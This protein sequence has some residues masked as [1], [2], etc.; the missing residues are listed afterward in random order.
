METLVI[1]SAILQNPP[2]SQESRERRVPH[3]LEDLFREHNKLTTTF[4]ALAR[5]DKPLLVLAMIINLFNP[6]RP[7]VVNKE[8]VRLAA[9]RYSIL[10]QAYLRS[11]A[12]FF[13]AR[14]I[15][16]QI[17]L[18]LSEVHHFGEMC[19]QHIARVTPSELQPLMRELFSMR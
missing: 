8:Q 5:W 16:P 9:E 11:K 14:T 19:A 1:R 7:G 12:S 6:E 18:K 10:L 2:Q 13:E 15:Y 4:N 17:F 3:G